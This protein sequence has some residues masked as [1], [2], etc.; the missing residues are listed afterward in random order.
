M[1]TEENSTKTQP[2]GGETAVNDVQVKRSPVSSPQNEGVSG[3]AAE[4]GA[5]S[6]P[7]VNADAN[8]ATANSQPDSTVAEIPVNLKI[9]GNAEEQPKVV[10]EEPSSS[11]QVQQEQR[12]SSPPPLLQHVRTITLISDYRQQEEENNAGATP[13]TTA[14]QMAAQEHLVPSE[15]VTTTTIYITPGVVEGHQEEP[16]YQQ[17]QQSHYTDENGE[18]YREIE[19]GHKTSVQH[20]DLLDVSAAA[21]GVPTGPYQIMEEDDQDDRSVFLRSSRLATFQVKISLIL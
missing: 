10:V 4:A 12:R 20:I 6:A 21:A 16:Y 5:E 14:N 13:T 2:D 1:E 8:Q 17:Q 19:T 15:N 7:S 11:H 9:E 3:A 18:R